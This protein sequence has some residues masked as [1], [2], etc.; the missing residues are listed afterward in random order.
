MHHFSL[1]KGCTSSRGTWAQLSRQMTSL[2]CLDQMSQ[3]GVLTCL[4]SGKQQVFPP[5]TAVPGRQP[6]SA[7]SVICV[8]VE[9]SPSVTRHWEV[10]SWRVCDI[11]LLSGT[12]QIP[13]GE[14]HDQQEAEG[15]SFLGPVERA[16]HGHTQPFWI[17]S[18]QWKLNAMLLIAHILVFQSEMSSVPSV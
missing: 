9:P 10:S 18:G 13:G 4:L 15:C 12:F 7:H 3:M 17:R 6:A 2:L 14:L 8:H 16:L 5:G 1:T 11:S